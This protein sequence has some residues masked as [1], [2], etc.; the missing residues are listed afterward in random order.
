MTG[1]KAKYLYVLLPPLGLLLLRELLVEDPLLDLLQL[2]PGEVAEGLLG[3]V[4]VLAPQEVV[5][6]GPLVCLFGIEGPK[7]RG[8]E[9]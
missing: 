5:H 6:R 7:G 8:T 9:L 3:R 2:V 1:K 4:P